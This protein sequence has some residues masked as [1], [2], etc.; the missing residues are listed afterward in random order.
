MEYAWAKYN[1]LPPRDKAPGQGYAV[2]LEQQAAML[3]QLR[4][5]NEPKYLHQTTC[6]AANGKLKKL[7]EDLPSAL[8]NWTKNGDYPQLPWRVFPHVPISCRV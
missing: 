7:A 1:S 3:E 2:Q 6:V 5:F 8:Q 4:S